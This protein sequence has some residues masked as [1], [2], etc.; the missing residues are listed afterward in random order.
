MIPYLGSKRD[1]AGKIYQTIK[2]FNPEADTLADLF[3][4]GFAISKYFIKNG[5]KV[6]ANDKNKQ[7][8]ALLKKVIFEKL[9]EKEVTKFVTRD[10]F[11]DIKNNPDKYEDW[12]VGFVECIWSFGNN[13]RNYMFGK[14]T[15]LYKQAGHEIVINKNPEP[16][17]K[18]I[19]NIPEKYID[20]ILKQDNWHKRRLA[21]RIVSTKL[22]TRIFELQQLQQLQ[23]LQQLQ[24]LENIKLF[25]DDYR[26]IE[27]PDNTVI[28]C[29][30]PYQGTAEY[31]EGAFNHKEFW[32]WT[33][34]KSKTHKVYIS[35]Y[36]APDDF[37]K[38]LE[39]Q[40]SSTLSGGHNKNQPNECLFI[41]K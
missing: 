20:G 31:K 34:E 38:I 23:R 18:L 24:Q 19:P 21:L 10:K 15:E 12:Y 27:I 41:I 22:K 6:I 8:I 7:V 2:N 32:E 40:R 36:H 37:K 33:R 9:D 11:L 3:C 26:N 25:S 28:Y 14:N 17:K 35:E 29:D 16:I 13:Q 30:P 5:W 4:G 39:F 1:S